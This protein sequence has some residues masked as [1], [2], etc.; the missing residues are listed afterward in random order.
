MAEDKP[1]QPQHLGEESSSADENLVSKIAR[2]YNTLPPEQRHATRSPDPDQ[3]VFNPELDAKFE[4]MLKQLGVLEKYQG[5]G[6]HKPDAANVA[7]LEKR[8]AQLQTHAEQPVADAA[9]GDATS[10]GLAA[11]SLQ[12]GLRCS[13]CGQPNA[14]STSFCATCGGALVQSVVLTRPSENAHEIGSLGTVEGLSQAASARN[15]AQLWK[16]LCLALFCIV[17]ALVAYQRAWRAPAGQ[18]S[19]FPSP[20]ATDPAA[21]MSSSTAAA[22]AV[23]PTSTNAASPLASGP[24]PNSPAAP[25]VSP[26]AS[27]GKPPSAMPDN[28]PTQ[29][30]PASSAGVTALDKRESTEIT[31]PSEASADAVP[32]PAILKSPRPPSFDSARRSEAAEAAAAE[33]SQAPGTLIFRVTPDY[34]AAA[35]R[36]HIQGTVILRAVIGMDGSVQQ[37]RIVSGNPALTSSAIEAVT[38]WRYTPFLLDGKPVEGETTITLNFKAD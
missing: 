38:K 36:D 9:Y 24:Q 19:G 33:D 11:A 22:P 15:S 4:N 14:V 6:D 37:V 3:P 2:A 10:K 5:T 1:E 29:V 16:L 7:L 12:E 27:A 25:V 26:T 8:I 20:S 32:A 18:Q 28:L 17:L 34:P 31:P 35:L 30:Q 23:N 13:Q 21:T